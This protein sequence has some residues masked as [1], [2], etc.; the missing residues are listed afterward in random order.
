MN[1]GFYKTVL[2]ESPAAYAYHKILLDASG[3]PCDY[4]FLEVNAAFEHYT[5]LY[6]ADIIGRKITEII[7][8][9]GSEEY[10]WIKAYGQVAL[11][12]ETVEFRQFSNKLGHWYRIRVFSPEKYYFI[13][14]FI[15]IS[16]ET[17]EHLALQNFFDISPD[18]LCIAD[19]KGCFLRINAAGEKTMGYLESNLNGME[20]DVL[21]KAE[22]IMYRKKLFEGPSIRGQITDAVVKALYEANRREK[23]HSERVSMIC[24]KMG[25]ALGCSKR[26][27]QELRTVGLL[28]DIGKVAIDVSIIDKPGPLSESEWI[29]IKRHPEIGYRILS[30]VNDMTEI[31]Q[32]ILSHHERWDG[33][34]YPRGICGEDIPMYAR[35]LAIADAY[36]AMTCERPYRKPMPQKQ[37]ENEL[38]VNQDK[39]FDARLVR[40]FLNDVA[41]ALR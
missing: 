14:N 10:N 34:G 29:E 28:H 21:K 38:A 33:T 17:E 15:D 41:P 16:F 18:L 37:V 3:M 11:T 5:G 30:A 40:I 12:G 32:S 2:D 8:S 31:A 4:E 13:T 22:D 35:I 36:D 19:M 39:Q 23:E 24:E 9:I 20:Y 7:P 26:V 27:I 1:A 25:H 6:A